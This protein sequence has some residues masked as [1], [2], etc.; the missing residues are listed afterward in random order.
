MILPIKRWKRK[1]ISVHRYDEHRVLILELYSDMLL[2][3]L[4]LNGKLMAGWMRLQRESSHRW[5]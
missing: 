5:I 2:S 3:S 1:D 4:H